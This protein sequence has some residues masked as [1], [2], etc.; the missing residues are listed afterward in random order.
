LASGKGHLHFDLDHNNG[1]RST[2][3]EVHDA[4]MLDYPSDL[5][6][7]M[8]TN[9]SSPRAWAYAEA[10][11]E[12]DLEPF[13]VDAPSAAYPFHEDV[14][15]EMEPVYDEVTEY[16]MLD[17]DGHHPAPLLTDVDLIDVHHHD[18]ST[19]HSQDI[20]APDSASLE[21]IPEIVLHPPDHGHVFAQQPNE[22]E[23]D[24]QAPSEPEYGG[25]FG[26]SH[27]DNEHTRASVGEHS[28]HI[29]EAPLDPYLSEHA[30]LPA[31]NELQ[32][33]PA[34][35][36]PETSQPEPYDAPAESSDNIYAATTSLRPEESYEGAA[37]QEADNGGAYEEHHAAAYDES[38]GNPV[39][40]EG[41]DGH[42]DPSGDNEPDLA[43]YEESYYDHGGDPHEITDGI[44]IE[45]PP[46]VLIDI[47][48]IFPQP[49]VYLFNAPDVNGGLSAE[50]S[51]DAL[52]QV[53]VLLQDRP[54]LFYEPL[55]EVFASLRREEHVRHVPD[56]AIGELTVDAYD[57]DLVVSEVSLCIFWRTC[58]AN[59]LSG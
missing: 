36:H 6:V 35:D 2:T 50:N 45:P 28:S 32:E 22:P 31:V 20:P 30:T 4:Q 12:D 38:E 40:D 41:E 23:L 34:S 54:T 14:E 55:S 33:E 15:V 49:E 17:D 8:R 48:S 13:S 1:D 26:G 7:H 25:D 51:S 42:Q 46:P 16:D 44:Y 10:S 59:W 5:D 39:Q 3:M 37:A 43:Q 24:Q 56:F 58:I 57:L 29:A 21:H 19:S 9:F 27:S 47:P 53:M 52:V 18:D 11:M